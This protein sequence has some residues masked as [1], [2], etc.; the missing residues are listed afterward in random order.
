MTC[1][2]RQP[3]RNLPVLEMLAQS[4]VRN[5]DYPKAVAALQ[6]YLARLPEGDARARGDRPPAGASAQQQAQ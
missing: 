5:E 3:E 4:A 1:H 2:Q 6:R